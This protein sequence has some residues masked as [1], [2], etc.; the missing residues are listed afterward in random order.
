MKQT[1]MPLGVF[2]WLPPWRW[3]H[4]L[5]GSAA[6]FDSGSERVMLTF[7]DGPH[8][9]RTPV[10]LDALALHDVQ[11]TFFVIGE[12]AEKHYS[13]VQRVVDEGHTLGNHSWSHRWLPL[14]SARAVEYE[15]D[16]C[17]QLLEGLTGR[18]SRLVRPPFG[19]TNRAFDAL[20]RE[21]G[22]IAVL[23]SL[24]TFDYLGVPAAFALG[25]AL[26]SRPG[27][28]LLFHD[29]N[30]FA[31]GT[32]G[33]LEAWLR[34]TRARGLRVGPFTLPTRRIEPPHLNPV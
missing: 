18:P 9:E 10:I 5:A 7:D 15:I 1:L 23:W 31:R 4:R 2:P 21:R 12:R 25:R 19:W 22:L 11:A 34:T 3:L 20:M 13:L 16:R 14:L 24:S 30:A 29:G 28:I 26:K 8:P 33:G 32:I 6:R 17:Q 27:D